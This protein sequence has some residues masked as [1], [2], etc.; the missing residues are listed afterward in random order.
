MPGFEVGVIQELCMKKYFGVFL[1]VV[2]SATNLVAMQETKNHE[3]TGSFLTFVELTRQLARHMETTALNILDKMC[4]PPGCN[5]AQHIITQAMTRKTHRKNWEAA[6]A[7]I[8]DKD[9]V[10]SIEQLD[11]QAHK[12]NINDK[13]IVTADD[14]EVAVVAYAQ[15]LREGV[16][17]L[18]QQQAIVIDDEKTASRN[19]GGVAGTAEIIDCAGGFTITVECVDDN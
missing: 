13:K 17:A 15:Q 5:V 1:A 6:L 9:F 8:Q 11:K 10:V 18:V 2:M 19:V 4:P 14:A 3:T 7:A 12:V 16:E